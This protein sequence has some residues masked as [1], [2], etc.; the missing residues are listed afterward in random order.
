MFSITNK[1]TANSCGPL[2]LQDNIRKNTKNQTKKCVST[3]TFDVLNHSPYSSGLASND[4]HLFSS[5]Q[6]I[7]AKYCLMTSGR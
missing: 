3:L 7:L 6:H 4:L 2:V 5:L 1:L